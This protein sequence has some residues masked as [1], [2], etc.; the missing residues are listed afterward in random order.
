MRTLLWS[1]LLCLA[2][3][4]AIVGS[5]LALIKP[6]TPTGFGHAGWKYDRYEDLESL[7]AG[8]RMVV[9][10]IEGPAI[11]R[12]I[13]TTRHQNPALM[14]RG[15]VLEVWFDDA[16]KPA[17]MSPLADFFGDGCSG[18]SQYFSTPLIECAPWSY[19]TYLPMPFEHRARV[20]LRND[21]GQDVMNYSYVEWE[22]LEEWDDSL[23]YLHASYSRDRFQLTPETAHTFFEAEGTGH[24]I[25]RQF[26]VRTEEPIF[27]A[28]GTV[29]EGNNEVDIDGKERALDYLGTEDSFTFSWGFQEPFIG[30]RAGMP[31]VV[32]G[33]TNSLSIYRF[34]DHMPIRFERSLTWRI[35]WQEERLF[36]GSP[37]WREAVEGGGC[38][39]DYATVFYW[40]QD[41]PGGYEHRP[42]ADVGLRGNDLPLTE[43]DLL[44]ALAA[45]PTD[46]RP[47]NGFDTADDLDRVRV[48]NAYADTHPFWIDQPRAEGGHPGNPNPGRQGILALHAASEV[49]PGYVLLKLRVPEGGD[50]RLRVIVSG[51]PYE[52]PGRSDFVL[53]VGIAADDE[54]LWLGERVI[55]AGTPPSEAN[56]QTLEYELGD[57]PDEE[58]GIVIEA[59][60][61]GAVPLMNE[62]AFIDEVSI[63]SGDD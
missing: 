26:S 31:H 40:Y 63:L 30:L 8:A 41:D 24:L 4:P 49:L 16:D 15:I 44:R 36:T 11:I 28:F 61:G 62:E 47:A 19:N 29:M 13:H 21:T 54:V 60:Y 46:D 52:A 50:A 33:D 22:P 10:D 55:D 2:A 6:D 58:I 7:D 18:A 12:H 1:A 56:W 20:I 23:G 57:R 34:H 51:D 17:V 9:A 53:R 14:A 38:M 25:G 45:M 5:E 48:L 43:A 27:R 32:H 35:N 59:S 37:V 42:L 39:V 3:A